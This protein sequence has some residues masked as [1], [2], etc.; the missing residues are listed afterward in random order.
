ML[1]NFTDEDELETHQVPADVQVGW[2]LM[3]LF[4]RGICGRY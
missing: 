3:V 2:G 1:T 4:T